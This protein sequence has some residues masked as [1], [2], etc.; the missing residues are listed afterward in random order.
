[1]RSRRKLS[2]AVVHNRDA[3]GRADVTDVELAATDVASA[4]RERG[5]A[6][7]VVALDGS[8]EGLQALRSLHVDLV[9]NLC[10]ALAGESRHEPVVPHLCE[11]LG[12]PYTGSAPLGLALALRKDLSRVLL[13]AAGVPVASGVALSEPRGKLPLGFP[14]IVKPAAEDA[15]VGIDRGSVVHDEKATKARVAALLASHAGPILVEEY[16]AGREVYVSLVGTPLEALPPHEID[17]SRMPEGCPPIVTW[18]GK[19]VADSPENTG[20]KPIEAKLTRSLRGMLF[21][22]ATRAAEVL[23]L[24]DYAR[25]DFRIDGDRPYVIDVNPNCDLSRNAGMARAAAAVGM[26]YSALVKLLVRY[27]LRR[28]KPSETREARS[29]RKDVVRAPQGASG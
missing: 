22:L 5:H 23:G 3:G 12:L 11:L 13:G 27:A 8:L 14:R 21:G 7:Q 2:V 10:E 17:F 28:R 15:S 9:F 24:R 26:D 1:V 16:I 29:V 6:A 20:S 4:L 25:V 19:W 18:A